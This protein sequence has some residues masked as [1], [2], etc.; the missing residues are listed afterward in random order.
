MTSTYGAVGA[1]VGDE[2]DALLPIIAVDDDADDGS[3]RHRRERGRRGVKMVD[4][5]DVDFGAQLSIKYP[6]TV[7]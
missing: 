6:D 2:T 4:D 5:A 1:D 7:L 3:G